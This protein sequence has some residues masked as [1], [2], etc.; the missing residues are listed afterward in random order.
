MWRPCADESLLPLFYV[1]IE[2]KENRHRA[3]AR[4]RCPV[5]VSALVGPF[6]LTF[7]H[8]T[9]P[10]S[11]GMRRTRPAVSCHSAVCPLGELTMLS[12]VYAH[13]NNTTVGHQAHALPE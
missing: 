13:G 8:T 11:P 5:A 4:G 3:V 6:A 1:G 10:R 9:A 2:G 7:Y 12:E